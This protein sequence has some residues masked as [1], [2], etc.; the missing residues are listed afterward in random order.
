MVIRTQPSRIAITI[1]LVDIHHYSGMIIPSIIESDMC[2]LHIG[3][4]RIVGWCTTDHYTINYH[5]LGNFDNLVNIID[6]GIAQL[7]MTTLVAEPTGLK[8]LLGV[9]WVLLVFPIPSSLPSLL[10]SSR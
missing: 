9:W 6:L 8:A 7:N 3:Y 1:A 2:Y 5:S 4:Y 10:I